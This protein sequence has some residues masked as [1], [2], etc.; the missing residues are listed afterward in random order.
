MARATAGSNLCELEMGVPGGAAPAGVPSIAV[1]R[2]TESAVTDARTGRRGMRLPL[3]ERMGLS[4]V[5][6]RV[7]GVT[8]AEGNVTYR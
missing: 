1:V 3:F 4:R 6:R 2:T 7:T 5:P 8:R